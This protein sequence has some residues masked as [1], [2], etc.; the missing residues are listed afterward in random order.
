MMNCREKVKCKLV[1]SLRRYW[2]LPEEGDIVGELLYVGQEMDGDEPYVCA[3]VILEDGR[4]IGVNPTDM[5]FIKE[6]KEIETYK[7]CN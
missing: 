6:K 5:T 2:K 4:V 1:P 3:Y 7:D